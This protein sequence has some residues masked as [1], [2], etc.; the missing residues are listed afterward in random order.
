MFAQL[1]YYNCLKLIIF[2]SCLA[3]I[4]I[5]FLSINQLI[6]RFNI[7]SKYLHDFCICFFLEKLRILKTSLLFALSEIPYLIHLSVKL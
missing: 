7:Y 3:I 5:M 4:A 2:I 1:S 6:N